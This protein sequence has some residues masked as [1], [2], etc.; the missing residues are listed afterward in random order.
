[1]AQLFRFSALSL[2]EVV[3]VIPVILGFNPIFSL[4]LSAILIRM[5]EGINRFVI[6]GIVASAIGAVVV[7]SGI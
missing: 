3:F 2:E 1:I 7:A 6:I 4:L 5:L